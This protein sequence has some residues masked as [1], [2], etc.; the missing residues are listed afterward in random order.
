MN[1][2]LSKRWKQAISTMCNNI[3]ATFFVAA[4]ITPGFRDNPDWPA[5]LIG[6][7]VYGIV[8]LIISVKFDT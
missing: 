6:Y 5:V 2:F 8:F 4:F 7:I 1:K 3:A